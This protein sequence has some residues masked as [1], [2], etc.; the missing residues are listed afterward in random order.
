MAFDLK[1]AAFNFPAANRRLAQSELE[2]CFRDDETKLHSDLVGM[3]LDAGHNKS[4]TTTTTSTNYNH[5][6][7]NDEDNFDERNL[8]SLQVEDPRKN[9]VKVS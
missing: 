3:S 4:R 1:E 9:L 7:E 5:D 8:F 6:D 2:D